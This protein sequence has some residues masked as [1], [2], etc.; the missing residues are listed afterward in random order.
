MARC[1]RLH[2]ALA[3]TLLAVLAG[4]T[5]V[6]TGAQ[7][8]SP[9]NRFYGTVQINGATA[10]DGTS[11]IALMGDAECARTETI[12]G[13]YR[14]DVPAASAR[15]G[16][17]GEGQTV[18]F[19]V[20]GV[21]APQS[22]PWRGA[23]FTELPLIVQI[24]PFGTAALDLGSPCIPPT[25]QARCDPAR[26]R[27]WNGEQEAW[28]L[29]FRA[30]GAPDPPPDRVF[31][32]VIRL[33]LEAGD[34]ALL[35]LFAQRLGWPYVRITAIHFRGTPPTEADE[36]VEI[37]NL[38][39]APQLMTGWRLRIASSGAEFRFQPG[40]V[41]QSGQRCRA[42]TNLTRADSCP[43]FGFGSTFGLWDNDT[44]TATLSV[45]VPAIV[46]DHT[47]YRADPL[48]QPPPPLLRGVAGEQ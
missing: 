43:G 18:R 35:A 10:P 46:A 31:A 34:P 25:G 45:D 16:C 37:A 17:G 9:P 47:A 26:L 39:G 8:P 42:Y 36:Y 4:L 15:P 40:A 6:R 19:R 30:L 2:R 14:L 28:N 32:E 23:S 20:A 11:V 1:I 24:A 12:G 22:A 27:L 29:L 48:H 38:G 5:P 33:R 3:A 44:D 41:L 7:L 13:A 21:I